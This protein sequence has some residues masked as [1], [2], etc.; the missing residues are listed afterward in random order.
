V[1]GVWETLDAIRNTLGLCS[2]LARS[3]QDSK[4]WEQRNEGLSP[5]YSIATAKACR[6]LYLLPILSI[7]R[8]Y[9]R[10]A[11]PPRRVM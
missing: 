1:Y 7:P 6:K 3:H 10:L 2:L 8:C 4:I 9:T 5:S 11:V